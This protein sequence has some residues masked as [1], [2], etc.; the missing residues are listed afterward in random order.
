MGRTGRQRRGLRPEPEDGWPLDRLLVG[1]GTLRTMRELFLQDAKS[2]ADPKRA[3]DLALWCGVTPQGAAKSMS[4]LTR[5]ELVRE[6]P[7]DRPG[8]APAYR[9]V[10]GHPLVT[11][12]A[13]LFAV[14]ERAWRRQV[15]GHRERAARARR[16][17]L[18][19]GPAVPPE[20]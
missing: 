19:P 7:P 18:R 20:R 11:P 3:W 1:V 12:L 2:P 5:E 17:R 16:A 8:R 4:R 6:L 15:I 14:E 9:L 13:R 10:R